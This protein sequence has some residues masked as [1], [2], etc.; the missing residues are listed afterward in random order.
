MITTGTHGL[1]NWWMKYFLGQ[2]CTVP[3]SQQKS[4]VCSLVDWVFFV[5]GLT[6]VEE[7]R[8]VMLR[9]GEERVAWIFVFNFRMA[10]EERPITI[11]TSVYSQTFTCFPNL[12][13]PCSFM[14]REGWGIP[15]HIEC[16]RR[17][18]FKYYFFICGIWNMTQMTLAIEQKQT[19]RRG[20][21]TCGCQAGG[22]G[23]GMDGEF[24][25]MPT[26]TFRLDKQWGPTV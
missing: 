4:S 23:S 6:L 18:Q 2:K 17:I 5:H 25:E 14:C 12:L 22:G 9:V 1:E 26:M 13:Y 19:H 8:W 10:E 21:Q 16:E 24:G 20:E 11:Q 3:V 15:S 7:A